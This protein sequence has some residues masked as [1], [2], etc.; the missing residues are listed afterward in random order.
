MVEVL[1][2]VLSRVWLFVTSWTVGHQAPLSMGFSQQEYWS[3]LPPSSR[4]SSQLRGR[5]HVPCLS[6]T[7]RQILYHWATCEAHSFWSPS[8]KSA[9]EFSISRNQLGNMC[10]AKI[11]LLLLL[12]IYPE[13]A[14]KRYNE[15]YFICMYTY[16]L[17]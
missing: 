11:A 10:R 3:G 7:G 12:E 2:Q 1:S 6:C 8:G 15:T 4:G 9:N 17:Q 14:I 16:S 13:E 5:T